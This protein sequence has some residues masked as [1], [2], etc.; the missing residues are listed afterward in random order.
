M[1][2]AASARYVPKRVRLSA[3]Y[4]LGLML[5][6]VSQLCTLHA[7]QADDADMR[8]LVDRTEESYG[9][10]QH[11]INGIEY[12]NLHMQTQG[13]KFLDEDK[14]YRGRIVIDHKTYTDVHLKYDI[15]GQQVLLLIQH[16][17]GGNKQIILNNLR[18]K[19]FEINNRQFHKLTFPGKGTQFYQVLGD[20]EMACLHFHYKQEIPKP[21]DQN[22]LSEF[23]DTKRRSYL[24]W[25]ST[26]N[27]FK[28]NR[29]F[30]RI[31]PGHQSQVKSYLR[32]HKWRVKKLDDPHMSRLVSFCNSITKNPGAQ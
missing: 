32:R 3:F 22:T 7:Q 16:P 5:F 26:L 18:I 25:Q 29:S 27:E 24:Y 8:D 2:A 9:P 15:F 21:I 30:I 19:E 6:L 11:L 13:H 31:F 1:A 10:D 28:S 20:K 12:F 14:Y 23:T 17:K 4:P